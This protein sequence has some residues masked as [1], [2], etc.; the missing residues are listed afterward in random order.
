MTKRM[1]AALIALVGLFVALYLTLYKVG[2]IGELACS[3]GSCEAVQTSRWSTFLGLPVAAWGL[4]FYASVLAV[5][6]TGL[7]E[8]YEDSRPLAL[9]MLALT[10]WGALFS[11]WLTYLE[12]FV[13]RAICQWCVISAVLAVGLTVVSYLDWRELRALE[14]VDG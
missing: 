11:L 14:T 1:L 5:A 4:A 7:M 10:A 8:R 3:I 9:G 12:L 13:I 6:L 2:V